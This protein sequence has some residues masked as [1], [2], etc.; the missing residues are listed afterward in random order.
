MSDGREAQG[1]A[2]AADGPPTVATV[3]L[4]GALDFMD[5]HLA[6]HAILGDAEK[7]NARAKALDLHERR[8]V[9]ESTPLRL[10]V[11][12]NRRCQLRCIH[13]DITHLPESHLDLGVIERLFEQVGDG[14][15]EVMPYT[16]GEPT[17]C[18]LEELA[19]LCRRHNAYMTFTTNGMLL[20]RERLAG[21]VD[22]CGRVVFSFHSHRAEAF[23]HI[24]PG[25]EYERVLANLKDA[26]ELTAPHDIQMMTGICLLDAN[27]DDLAHWFHF[28]ADLGIRRVGFTSLHPNTPDRERIDPYFTRSP[29][30]VADK[31]GAGLEAAIARG[32]FVETNVAEGYYTRFPENRPRR[33]TRFDFLQDMNALPA[34]FQPG[35]CALTANMITVEHDGTVLPCC[36]GHLSLGNLHEQDFDALW[37]GPRMQRLRETFFERSLFRECHGCIQHYS[38]VLHPSFPSMEAL[39]TSYFDEFPGARD[40]AED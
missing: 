6:R 11:E 37:N 32:V 23:E 40:G 13:C 38:D 20:D 15:V 19:V 3:G 29:G 12:P 35:F 14:V 7:A 5:G 16:G 36:R 21:I 9:W 8:L 22:A 18:P 25:G 30:E 10:Q 27:I 26:V 31:V 17:L 1:D 24:E 39:G 34:V 2:A 33:E 4:D 28:V